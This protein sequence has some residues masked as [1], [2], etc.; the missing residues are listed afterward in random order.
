M[1]NFIAVH[2]KVA[3]SNIADELV[4]LLSEVGYN[5]FE[6]TD[7]LLKAYVNES[8]FDEITIKKIASAY[9]VEYEFHQIQEQNW[10]AIW[11]SNFDPVIVD[12]FAAIRADFHEPI[13]TVEHEI[14]IT[15]KMSF[16]TGHHA[17]TFMM[18]QQMRNLSLKNKNVFDFGTGTGIL[19]ILAEKLGASFICAI[20]NDEWSINNANENI[21]Y[22]DCHHIQLELAAEPPTH[23]FEVILA[24][25]NKH[26]ILQYL[27]PLS[28]S[29]VKGGH[30]LLSG[31]LAEDEQDILAKSIDFQ[32]K[33]QATIQKDKWICMYFTY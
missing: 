29:L 10:N 21:L 12:D 9:S 32:L 7:D 6:E 22:N 4:G 2:F 1:N 23:Q 30:L 5:G 17:T 14:I 15:P 25:I 13:T 28:A 26:I 31:L 16:G 3:S 19:A 27:Q 18:M 11:E 24:N 20:D 8:A 33:H